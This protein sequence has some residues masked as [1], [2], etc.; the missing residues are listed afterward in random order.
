MNNFINLIHKSNSHTEIIKYYDM[1]NFI[2]LIHKNNNDVYIYK[3]GFSLHPDNNEPYTYNC[4]R[5]EKNNIKINYSCYQPSYCPVYLNYIQDK[6]IITYK[7][8]LDEI[9]NYKGDIEVML[10]YNICHITLDVKIFKECIN[11]EDK[12]VECDHKFNYLSFVN[13]NGFL[14]FNK[15][16]VYANEISRSDFCR[17]FGY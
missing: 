17:K 3:I 7:Q 10:S 12:F 13:G 4:Y 2:N 6:Q 1:N 11:N 15:K 16:F 5:Y 8:V 9:K 14:N